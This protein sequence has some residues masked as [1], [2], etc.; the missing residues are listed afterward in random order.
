MNSIDLSKRWKIFPCGAD[1][2]PLTPHG[3]KDAS[4]DPDQITRWERQYPDC[5]WG[6][7]CQDNNF[8]ALDVDPDGI[9]YWKQRTSSNHF[10]YGPC[11]Q[12][13]RGGSHVLFSLPD[14]PVPNNAGKLAPGIDLRSAGYICTGKGYTW[15]QGHTPEQK[16]QD[17]PGWLLDLIRKM[18]QPKERLI[19]DAPTPTTPPEEAGEYW[20]TKALSKAQPGNRNETGFWLALQLRDSGLTQSQATQYMR[21]YA[22]RVPGQDYAEW[23]ALTSLREAYSTAPR[24]PAAISGSRSKRKET[25]MTEEKKQV[26]TLDIQAPPPELVEYV[27]GYDCTDTGNGQRFISLH[28]D[29]VRWVEAAGKWY[30]WDGKRWAKDEDGEAERLAKDTSRSILQEAYQETDKDKGKALTAWAFKSQGRTQ[31]NNMLELAKSEPGVT[32]SFDQFDRDPYQLNLRNGTLNLKTGSLNPHNRH[33]L[34]TKLV[35][36]DYDERAKCP[37]WLK[38]LDEIMDHKQ[39]LIDYLQRAIGYCLTGDTSEQVFFT[40]WGRGANGKSVFL[41]TLLNTIGLDY[42][43]NTAGKT[44][45][46]RDRVGGANNDIARLK[47]YRFVTINELPGRGRLDESKIKELTGG[48]TITA[49]FLFNEEFVYRPEFK[50]FIRTNHKP[51]ITGVD[52]GIWRRVQMIPFVVTIPQDKQDTKLQEKLRDEWQGILTWAVLGCLAWQDEGLKPPEEVLAATREYRK[53]QD[54]M[55]PFLEDR[56]IVDKN[57]TIKSADLYSAYRDWAEINGEKAM[58]STAFGRELFERGYEK[59]RPSLTTGGLGPTTYSGI[60]L[61]GKE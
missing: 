47:G 43:T 31:I 15:L 20:L 11:Q 35:D 21:S 27:R 1:K 8:F 28:G 18:T 46:L 38:F 54:T 17:A 25:I 41:E 4:N 56:C 13:P 52:T 49:R 9:E 3:F 5:L 40:C 12:T 36:L 45:L 37:R 61:K 16:I 10:E 6:I 26:L 19:S 23:E 42:S 29:S 14:F 58:S 30:C 48:D 2:R 22:S 53:E 33:D 44:V 34:I 59:F 51:T 39:H 24:K 32:V 7:P 55:Q 60:A 57:H 50:L